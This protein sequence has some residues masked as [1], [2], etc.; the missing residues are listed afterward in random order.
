MSGDGLSCVRVHTPTHEKGRQR[1]FVTVAL[2]IGI[3]I[4]IESA[5]YGHF[6]SDRDTDSDPLI[7]D[8]CSIFGTAPIFESETK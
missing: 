2:G 5:R 1:L 7:A 8:I 6:D 4:G 3:G